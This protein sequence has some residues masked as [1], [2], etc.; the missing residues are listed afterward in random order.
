ME[1]QLIQKKYFETFIE[2]NKGT[3]PIA[4]LGEIFMNEQK[5]EMPDL[6]YIRF[7][8]GEVYFHN[9]DYEAAIFKWEN[10]LNE[11]EPWAKK[12]TADAYYQLGLLS[13]AE[14]IYK[15]IL[16]DSPLLST[17]VGLNLFSLYIERGKLDAALSVIKKLVAQN[18][19]YP[20]VTDLART[21]FEEQKD[22]ENAVELAVR[23]AIRTESLKWFECIKMYI[24]QGFANKVNT[25]YFSECLMVLSTLNPSLFEQMIS[26]LW[27]AYKNEG[28]YFSWLKEMNQLLLKADLSPNNSWDDLTN[29]LQQAFFEIV[30]GKY[31]IKDLQEIVPLKLT[32]WLHLA[33]HEEALFASTATLSWSELFPGS[34]EAEVVSRAEAIFSE[35]ENNIDLKGECAQ[36]FQS[37]LKWAEEREMG[38]NSRLN[39]MFDKLMDFDVQNIFILGQNGSGK[40][41]FIHSIL[42]DTSLSNFPTSSV[43]MYKHDSRLEIDE[44]NDN[45]SVE[46]FNRQEFLERMGRRRNALESIIEYKQPNSFLYENGIT[47]VDTPGLNGHYGDRNEILKYMSAADTVFYVIDSNNPFSEVDKVILSHIREISPEIPIHFLLN[48]MDKTQDEQEAIRIFDETGLEVH[49]YFPDAKL[50]AFS[51]QYE[52]SKQ[53]SDLNA[54]VKLVK[55]NRNIEVIRLEKMLS[56]IRS[57]ITN[58]LQKRIDVENYLIES[59]RWNE[60]MVMKLNGGLH[61]LQDLVAEKSTFVTKS[62]RSIR[63]E[64]EQNIA[65]EIP[66]LL[67]ECSKL[68]REDRNLSKIHIEL[69]K[70][71]NRRI[72]DYLENHALSRYLNAL[73]DWISKSSEELVEGQEFL[74]EMGEGFNVLYGEERM[75][76]EGDMKVVEDW[77]RDIDRLT[78]GFQLDEINILLRNTPFQLLL[79]S[80]GKLFGAISQNNSLLNNKYKS[81]V[82]NEDYAETVS[83]AI[84]QFFQPFELFERSIE[85]DIA[86]FFRNSL[87]SLNHALEDARNQIQSNEELLKEMNTNPEVYRDPLTLFEVRLRQVE[88]MSLAGKSVQVNTRMV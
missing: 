62:F 7:A 68:I 50:F 37:I 56:F 77:K 84:K 9:K 66:K 36:L 19:D 51:S 6:S 14:D 82:E 18:P 26:S 80:A 45:G 61:Q 47:F 48:K 23:E 79:K 88:W 71:M 24:E 4:V 35:L 13:M 43:V 55:V 81:F 10:I 39:W 27:K 58:L 86:L 64:I 2:L 31:L 83:L 16:T 59:A 41:S 12:N 54:F 15:A 67:R 5:N 70:E 25:S 49:T 44:I 32:N 63:E 74:T 38:N 20:H 34:I 76:L 17:E 85:R 33:N 60:E 30:D 29:F 46:L 8:Q 72:Q 65:E 53:L 87:N 11:L 22:W 57:T 69:N 52:R 28:T 42:G 21:F 40:S 1:K 78:S 73:L 3:E 75:S